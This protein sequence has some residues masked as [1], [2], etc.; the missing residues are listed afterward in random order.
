M[1]IIIKIKRIIKKK[2]YYDTESII[3]KRLKPILYRPV[4]N[5]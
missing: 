5:L 4:N 3:N 2:K 1:T